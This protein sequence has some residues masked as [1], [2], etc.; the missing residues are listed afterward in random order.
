MPPPQ[1]AIEIFGVRVDIVE[2]FSGEVV[3]IC[4]MKVSKRR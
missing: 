4:K 1:M 3:M 2:K